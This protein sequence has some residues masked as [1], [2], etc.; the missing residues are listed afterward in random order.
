MTSTGRVDSNP[1]HGFNFLLLQV[2]EVEAA[3]PD[4]GGDVSLPDVGTAPPEVSGDVAVPSV[5]GDISVDLPSADVSVTAPGVKAEGGDGS[6]AAGLV[7]GGAAALGGVVAA[8]GL[9]GDKPEGVDTEVGVSGDVKPTSLPAFD[10]SVD[11]GSFEAEPSSGKGKKRMSFTKKMKGLM[12]KKLV[13]FG[14]GFGVQV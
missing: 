10:A 8:V 11:S 1:A 4:L 14:F 6:L 13:S 5:E 9:A 2:P 7:A 3:V 12:K